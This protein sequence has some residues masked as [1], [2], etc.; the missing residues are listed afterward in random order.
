MTD[1]SIRIRMYKQG[2]GDCFLVSLPRQDGSDYYILIDCGAVTGSDPKN[3][4]AA[5]QDISDA[6][7]KRLDLLVGTHEH[8]DHLSGF[9]QA[10]DIFND[11]KVKQVWLGW[12]EDLSNPDAQALVKKRA[13][14]VSALRAALAHMNTAAVES[15]LV[16]SIQQV[17]AFFGE[18]DGSGDGEGLGATGGHSL[19]TTREAMRYLRE[20]EDAHVWYRNP[21]KDAPQELEG[22]QG[23]RVYVLGP[24]TDPKLLKQDLPSKSG[25]ET[26]GMTSKSAEDSFF[27]ALG[28]ATGQEEYGQLQPLAYPFDEY[29]RIPP[30]EAKSPDGDGFFREHYGFDPDD[31]DAWRR[32]DEDWLNLAGD[33][34][35]NLDSDTNNTSLVLAF[36]VGEPGAGDVLLFAADA[37]VGNWLSWGGLSWQMKDSTG[38]DVTVTGHDLLKRTVFYKVGHHGSHNATLSTEGLDLMPDGK[39]VAMLPVVETMAHKK[40]WTAMPFSPL[41]EHLKEKSK[42]RVIRIDDGLPQREDAPNLTDAEWEEFTNRAQDKGLYIEYSYPVPG[43]QGTSD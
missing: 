30:G 9:N 24:P 3:V 5:A 27:A 8:W 19:R 7:D 39:L 31:H 12:T 10:R 17:L 35:L 13:A 32:I 1:S 38:K 4:V 37:Q 22:V 41:V 28:A 11:F 18:D 42:G 15:N 34:A 21:D 26:Y 40:R 25:H 33:L 14:K 43:N 36:E 6:T 20:R 29:Y 2:L 23:V 16:D